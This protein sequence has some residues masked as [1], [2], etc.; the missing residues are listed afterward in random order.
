M[1]AALSVE[2]RPKPPNLLDTRRPAA[3]VAMVC[4]SPPAGYTR[5]TVRV[6]T[7]ETKRRGIVADVG[8]E[9]IRKCQLTTSGSRGGRNVGVSELDAKCH[10]GR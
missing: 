2:P 8:R 10:V 4:G 3:S 5:R 1:L 9:T 7:E 6:T